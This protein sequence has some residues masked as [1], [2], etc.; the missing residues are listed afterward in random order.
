MIFNY[1]GKELDL[2]NFTI[3][4]AGLNRLILAIKS[5]VTKMSS[6]NIILT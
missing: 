4:K 5:K 6:K 3:I 1:F 2:F